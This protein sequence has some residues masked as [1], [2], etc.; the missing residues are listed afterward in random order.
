M[1]ERPPQP[2]EGKLIADA[3]DRMNLSIREAAR[4]AGISYGRWRQIVTGY[5]NVSPGS[6]AR[7]RAP[8]KTLARMAA[9]VGVTAEQMGT[10]GQRPDAAEAMRSEPGLRGDPLDSF[11]ALEEI[12]PDSRPAVRERLGEVQAMI[13]TARL[14]HPDGPLRGAWIFGDGTPEQR[15]WDQMAAGGSDEAELAVMV[16][17]GWAWDAAT[18]AQAPRNP[19]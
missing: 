9:A 5:Q 4:R 16:A 10:E 8:A 13:R 1:N 15:F 2:P 6:Y 14:Y 11:T 18:K 17:F 7:V 19:G 12:H 3:A